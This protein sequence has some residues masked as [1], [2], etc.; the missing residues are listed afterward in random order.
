MSAQ[1]GVGSLTFTVTVD[2]L[3]IDEV[4]KDASGKEID[5][6]AFVLPEG[7]TQVTPPPL[8]GPQPESEAAPE[9]APTTDSQ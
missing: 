3:F 6:F 1:Q 9:S 5:A 8:A 4:P 7:A 2:K